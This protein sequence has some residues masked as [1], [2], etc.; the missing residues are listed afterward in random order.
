MITKKDQQVY[1]NGNF[2]FEKGKFTARVG[3]DIK[4]DSYNNSYYES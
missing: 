2:D 3:S 1:G 4:N